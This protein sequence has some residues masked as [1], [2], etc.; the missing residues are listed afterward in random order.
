VSLAGQPVLTTEQ[1]LYRFDNV[2][3]ATYLV[4]AEKEGYQIAASLAYVVTGQLRWN[5][6]ALSKQP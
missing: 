3:A 2:P 4:T 6:M 1:G 5:S